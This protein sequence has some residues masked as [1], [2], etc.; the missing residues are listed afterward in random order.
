MNVHMK[1]ILVLLA[2]A[3]VFASCVKETDGSAYADDYEFVLSMGTGD[4]G[5][6]KATEYGEDRWNENR[7]DSFR[8]YFYAADSGDDAPALFAWPTDSYASAANSGAV[9]GGTQ[10]LV[11]DPLAGKVSVRFSMS[12]LL[13]RTLF[14]TMSSC[15]VC[16]VA[17]ISGS[18][19]SGGS[20]DA[21]LSLPS[22]P[23]VNDLRQT[24]ISADFGP[25]GDSEPYG[26]VPECF[27]MFGEGKV[28]RN[29]ALGTLSG[30]DVQMFRSASKISFYV[31]SVNNADIEDKNWTPDTENMYA[32]FVNGVNR[33]FLA[34]DMSYGDRRG[35]G[36]SYVGRPRR[37][38]PATEG[39]FSV[40]WTHEMPWWSLFSEWASEEDG[41]APYILLSVPWRHTDE[42]GVQDRIFTCY[43]AVPFNS[44]ARRL[45][46][47][48]WYRIRLSVSIL[49][50]GDP[51]RPTEITPS[52]TILPWG[53]ETVRTEA[54]LLRYRYLMVDR[55]A[56][57]MHN[58]NSI[59]IPYF[60]SHPVRIV[61]ASLTTTN[62]AP[63]AGYVPEGNV[64]VSP[65]KYSVVNDSENSRVVFTHE[66]IND[67]RAD[68]DVSA[69]E[70]SFTI[71]HE[72][73]PDFEETLTV[74]QYPALYVVADLNSGTGNPN[75]GTSGN[76]SY[77]GDNGY[78][79]ING[80]QGYY[81]QSHDWKY[82]YQG[83]Y[84]DTNQDPYMYVVT[85]SSLPAGS[86]YIIGDPRTDN[87]SVPTFSG[88]GW[89]RES[90]TTVTATDGTR[91]Q[92]RYYYPADN[93]GTRVNNMIAPSFRI[94]SSYGVS[95]TLS[96]SDA[97]KRCA[98]Y[99][100][101]G[102]PAGRWRIP[103]KAEIE[104]M[105]MLADGGKIPVLLTSTSY[106][107]ASDGRAYSPGGNSTTSN[108]PVRCVYDEWYWT[109]RCGKTTFTWGDSAR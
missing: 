3:V 94:A 85:V 70:L 19:A 69:Y 37:L 59:S 64:V 68:Y 9:T 21:D 101:D 20:D 39:G 51:E 84:T 66:L 56:Y 100:E 35:S 8:L 74:I 82:V 41:D 2:V 96:Y 49:G 86:N 108:S 27:A 92:L 30:G 88:W 109:D 32:A 5:Q 45:D 16:A 7:I 63:T 77:G 43:Y 14:P 80:N 60:T 33:G 42:G 71:Q 13:V 106:Y 53:N 29:D 6:T 26:N 31:S 103:T 50:S 104:Y 105:V 11:A 58:T 17:N 52:Y 55:N 18:D 102:Y 28:V 54:E 72:D 4:F 73:D 67:Y 61:S 89:N 12:R 34:S 81:G 46:R 93:N 75:G 22:A 36:F 79:I 1:N 78:V 90:W 95:F 98:G 65:S 107:W 48:A 91:R 38:L 10:G 47:N 40:G 15:R 87:I 99:Q 57:E 23:T 25:A 83:E 44:V 62:L 76:S 97:Q 24:V